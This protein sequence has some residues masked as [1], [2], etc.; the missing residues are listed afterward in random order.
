[1]NYRLSLAAA[2]V[3][4]FGLAC[5]EAPKPA[6]AKVEKMATAARKVGT[7][8]MSITP[9][10]ETGGRTARIEISPDAGTGRL[11]DVTGRFE[12]VV[13]PQGLASVNLGANPCATAALPAPVKVTNLAPETIKNVQVQILGMALTGREACN[14]DGVLGAM[15]PVAAASPGLTFGAWNYGNLT[16]T[17]VNTLTSA[18]TKV[19]WMKFPSNTPVRFQFVVWADAGQAD[20]SPVGETLEVGQPVAWTSATSATTQ[21]DMCLT[22]PALTGNECPASEEIF[23]TDAV[24]AAPGPYVFS[25]VPGTVAG[26]T[27]W[28]RV[29]NVVNGVTGFYPSPWDSFT[30]AAP[31]NVAAPVI[32]APTPGTAFPADILANAVPL[33]LQWDTDLAIEASL[34]QVCTGPCPVPFDPA[35]PNAA[36]LVIE[37]VS[38]GFLAAAGVT[39]YEEDLSLLLPTDPASLDAFLLPGTYTVMVY[40]LDAGGAV[41]G[42]GATT[43]FDITPVVAPG[44]TVVAPLD[45]AAIPAND[46]LLGN[47]LVLEW[48]TE[49]SV[50]TASWELCDSLPCP[51]V[52]G[53]NVLGSGLELGAAA[54]IGD[55]FAYAVDVSALIPTDPATGDVWMLPGTYYWTVTNAPGGVAAGTSVTTSFIVA[56]ATPVV[57]VAGAVTAAAN[58]FTSAAGIPITWTAPAGVTST[59]IVICSTTPCN[60]LT[61]DLLFNTP[62]L[63]DVPGGTSYTYDAGAVPDLT[64]DFVNF[65]TTGG[66]LVPG[67]YYYTVYNVDPLTLLPIGTGTESTITV[68]AV[69][70]GPAA[71]TLVDPAAVPATNL[72]RAV[73]A[74]PLTWTGPKDVSATTVE[75]YDDAG[76]TLLAGALV[77]A[78]TGASQTVSTFVVA[79]LRTTLTLDQVYYWRVVDDGF[80]A[81][82]GFADPAAWSATGTFTIVP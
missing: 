9:I 53:A 32:A 60:D 75:F 12:T 79:D 66:Y 19:W 37:D 70:F 62:V 35:D 63:P 67:T 55:V 3:A 31:L 46:F 76:L 15:S 6:P 61:A 73:G 33:L 21:F 47:P 81:S 51:A 43:S 14:S 57:P 78:D 48:T 18:L 68:T 11:V 2:C 72:S 22:D 42:A 52:G 34:Y 29:L 58:A 7:F 64:Q 1:M 49:P 30:A 17:A 5:T 10:A 28:W 77:A 45:L 41:V 25:L 27:Y 39:S 65:P 8:T 20:L 54:F 23:V 4:A 44:P 24:T 16:G 36:N 26:A 71:F 59:E 50:D 56:P 13:V 40:N 69:P 74:I 82:F 38:I 80:M